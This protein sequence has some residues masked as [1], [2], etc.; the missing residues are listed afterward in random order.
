MTGFKKSIFAVFIPIAVCFSCN[1]AG[2][3]TASTNLNNLSFR[4]EYIFPFQDLH[5][6]S[7]SIVE[8]PNGDLLACWFE[9]SGERTAN[10]VVVKGA[11]L[12]KGELGWSK[13]FDLADTPGHPD[14]NPTLFIDK[15]NRL[16]LFW[17]VV[18][19]NRWE[20][21]ILKSRVSTNYQKSGAPEW[22][23]QDIILLKPDEEFAETIEYGFREA[24]TQG[25]AWAEYAPLYE[26]MIVEA[27]LDPKKRETGWMT[28]THPLQLPDGRILLPLYSDGYNLS[29][30]AISDDNGQSWQ[31]GLPIVGRGNIQPSLVLKKNGDLVAF[32]RDNGDE[33]GRV[34]KSISKDNGFNWSIAKKTSVP[35]PGTSVEAISLDDG[36]WVMVYN[37]IEN[38]RHSL[39]VSLS[40]DEGETWKWTRHLEKRGPGEGSFSY[41]SVIQAKNGIIHVTYSFHLTEKKTIKHVFFSAD[42]I[43]ENAG[44]D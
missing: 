8:L 16:H 15:D 2:A 33:P 37:D 17:I 43:K 40:D 6:H 36:D 25:V 11:R 34:I 5:V 31:P 7:S 44:E 41:P 14:C 21:S 42:W 24:N 9:G 3:Q 13:T 30:I 39:G 18:Q 22:E 29:L 32:M 1:T 35:N 38:G 19:A 10:D 20:T 12:K 26:R 27:A 4:S 23:W 28:R